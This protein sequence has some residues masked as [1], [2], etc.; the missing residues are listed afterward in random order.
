L[1]RNEIHKV[2]PHHLYANN[3]IRAVL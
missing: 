2:Y 1:T 3:Y